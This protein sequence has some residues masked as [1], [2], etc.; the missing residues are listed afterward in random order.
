MET[1]SIPAVSADAAGTPDGFLTPYLRSFRFF[2]AVGNSGHKVFAI[3]PGT[4]LAKIPASLDRVDQATPMEQIFDLDDSPADVGFPTGAIN[5]AT[6]VEVSSAAGQA[7]M[8]ALQIAGGAR[9][10]T[11]NARYYLFDY[12]EQFAVPWKNCAIPG[13]RVLNDG[14]WIPYPGSFIDGL[15]VHWEYDPWAVGTYPLPNQFWGAT[16]LTG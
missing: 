2:E 13:L 11:P 9:I 1:R 6:V 5:S 15:L 4:E 10:W 14:E 8:D 3:W 12:I 7:W 16:S